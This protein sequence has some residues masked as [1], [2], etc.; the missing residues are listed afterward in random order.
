MDEA[1]DGQK[2]A[3]QLHRPRGKVRKDRVLVGDEG[4][5]AA[6]IRLEVRDKLQIAGDIGG[7]LV[8]RAHHEAASH[9]VAD[10]PQIAEAVHAVVKGQTHGMQPLVMALGRRFVAEQ[11]TVS[12]RFKEP[13][14]AF[15]RPLPQREGHGAVGVCRLDGGEQGSEPLVGEVAVLAALQDEGAEAQLVALGAGRK[16]ILLGEAVAVAVGVPRTD[17][18]VEAVVLAD[19]ADLNQPADEHG[20]AVDGLPHGHRLLRQIRRGVGGSFVDQ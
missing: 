11:V 4:P 5:D 12:P 7:G 10:L 20:V 19:V 9:L 13:L 8:G 3:G 1:D 15:P 14:V 6:H 17:A 18:A 2:V 16:N